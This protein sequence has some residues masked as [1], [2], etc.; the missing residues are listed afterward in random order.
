MENASKALIIAG[1]ILISILIITIGI[2]IYRQGSSVIKGDQMSQAEIQTFN[3]R[4]TQ[5]AGTR[6]KG[7]EV[8]SLVEAVS[9]YDHSDQA[10]DDTYIT[11]NA[12][13]SNSSR[14]SETPS[15]AGSAYIKLEY[16]EGEAKS[17]VYGSGFKDTG[18]FKVVCVQDSTGRVGAIEITKATTK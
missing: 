10:S 12:A 18:L 16:S 15:T 5:Y 1:S 8:R 3:A 17:P 9:A 13:P 6:V 7:S 4:F 11:I 2:A 14:F